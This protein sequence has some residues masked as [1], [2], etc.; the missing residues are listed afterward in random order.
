ML[1]ESKEIIYA[2]KNAASEM[3]NDPVFSEVAD[4]IKGA[5]ISPLRQVSANSGRSDI[6]WA[7]LFLLEALMSAF[8]LTVFFRRGLFALCTAFGE[9]IR[10]SDFSASVRE[11]GLGIFNIFASQF[12]GSA[13]IIFSEILAVTLLMAVCKRKTSF[14]VSANT[15]TTAFMPSS[16]LI[17]AAGIAS[18][19]YIP[20][21][22]MLMTAAAVSA[23]LLSYAGIQ[24]MSRSDKP[25]FWI[26]IILV[27]VVI[28]ISFFIE[29]L[30]IGSLI[31]G[32]IRQF[33]N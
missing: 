22:A 6:L 31:N 11:E 17:A 15:M 30:C 29:R 33:A 16:I 4:T 24:K 3:K 5:L 2:V 14:F 23:V 12:L 13:A 1:P 21:A 28:I 19:F 8:G 32:L 18:I 7:I 20:A 27:S 9:D 25:I 10:Y 26:Y